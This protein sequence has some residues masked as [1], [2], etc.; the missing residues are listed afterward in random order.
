[1]GGVATAEY[2]AGVL[3][4]RLAKPDTDSDDDDTDIPVN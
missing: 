1:V 4:V 3:T 2:D